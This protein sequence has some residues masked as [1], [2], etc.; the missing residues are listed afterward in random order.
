MTVVKHIALFFMLLG[1]ASAQTWP[2]GSTR[3]ALDTLYSFSQSA[4]TT[5]SRAYSTSL[6][7]SGTATTA[8]SVALSASNTAAHA[9]QPSAI[10]G[11][12]TGT[13]TVNIGVNVYTSGVLKAAYGVNVSAALTGAVA[14][15]TIMVGPGMYLVSSDNVR[16]TDGVTL[17]G[18]G[19][20]ASTIAYRSS[21]MNTDYIGNNCTL[22]NIGYSGQLSA[23]QYLNQ[24]ML[25]NT[26]TNITIDSCRIAGG[27][28]GLV[29]VGCSGIRIVNS[30]LFAQSGD[31]L[32]M[33]NSE[34]RLERCS[35]I[36]DI[37]DSPW[38]GT[39][40]ISCFFLGAIVPGDTILTA[41]M[42]DMRAKGSATANR[43]FFLQNGA[44]CTASLCR[45]S[46]PLVAGT[47]LEIESGSTITEFGCEYATY[48]GTVLHGVTHGFLGASAGQSQLYSNGTNLFFVTSDGSKT[49][50]LTS[51]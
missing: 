7:A 36:S 45:V 29:L 14:G 35:V 20:R 50:K 51:N 9:V 2:P 38:A 44:V 23:G 39:Y 3:Q 40:A 10:A 16:L 13:N 34:A 49:N 48:S 37:T 22:V 30:E 47:D 31:A 25:M 43:G 12:I 21:T 26:K 24:G 41:S 11:L 33:H 4:S 42:C 32:A 18:S 1:T 19:A 17:I 46:T 27:A 15:D 6:T 5:A 28:D 8:Y